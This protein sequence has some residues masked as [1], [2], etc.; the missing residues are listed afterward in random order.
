M[1]KV[2]PITL[3]QLLSHLSG[4]ANGEATRQLVRAYE[5]AREAHGT[6]RRESRELFIEHD[7]AVAYAMCELGMDADTIAA[8][9]L[10]D[11]LLPHTG[12]NE[13]HLQKTFNQEIVSLVTALTRLEPYKS[14][15]D[16]H[17]DSRALEII[18]QAMLTI[19][20]G[21]IRV[22]LIHLADALQDL[23]K[24]GELS[25]AKQQELALDARDIYAPLANRL[26]I[27]QFKWE[28]EDLS[29]R[30][31]NPSRYRKI[32]AQLAQRRAARNSHVEMAVEKLRKKINEAG[33][34]ARVTGRPK[35][36]YSIYRKM[37]EKDVDF[38]RIYDVRAVRIIL[39]DD[40]PALCYQALGLVHSLWQ[41]I[42]QEFDD[43]I[44]RPKPNGY[45]SLHTAVVDENG[46]TLEVQIRTAAMHNEAERGVAAHWAYKEGSQANNALNNQIRWLRQF[47]THLQETDDSPIDNEAFK[48]EVLGERIYV[49]TPR[50]DLVD[51]PI[52]S[53][54]IDFAYQ[55]HTEVG[56]RCRGARINGKMVSLDYKL[57]SGE[58]VEIITANRGGPSRDWLNESLGYTASARTRSKVRAWFRQQERE[59]NI[60][61]GREIVLRELRRLGVSDVYTIKDIAAALKH[62]D[63]EQFL[64][65]VGFGDI[66]SAQIGGA[67]APMQQKLKEDDELLPLLS[68]TPKPT[69]LTVKG[70]SGLFTKIAQCC[71]PIPPQP[72]M[73]YITRGRGV[74]IHKKNCSQL[75]ATQE[76]ERWIE[77]SWGDKEET[78]PIPVII[79]A[80]RRDGIM[81]EISQILKGQGINISQAK[82]GT[83]N[84]VMTIYLVVDITT[85]DQLKRVLDK[86][87]KLKNVIE[88]ERRRWMD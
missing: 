32:A 76:P 36:I 27:W 20:E 81:E 11:I 60:H 45:R 71:N 24:A 26:G 57:K 17:R 3:S 39:A 53:T 21:D 64:A 43:Y 19:I 62:D 86:F 46:Q 51:L 33:L 88:V 25:E 79:K 56:H 75:K 12:K 14:A 35:H 42:P 28:L 5:F 34:K 47:L 13:E 31:L 54:P 78:Y 70:L 65:K 22:I 48:A 30:Y 74:T 6:T 66:S 55:I 23:R 77:V 84:S 8:G 41:P 80:Y 68:E 44:A 16:H 50:G 67:I 59:Q 29:F 2:A 9:L 87:D 38:D 82:M 7:L 63:V 72:I 61:Q 85:L 1:T 83:A 15:H 69:G 40:D 58:Q 18:R 49:F 10:H 4:R 52:N 73:G 37:R